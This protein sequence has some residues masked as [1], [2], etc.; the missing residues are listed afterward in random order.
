MRASWWMASS[1]PSPV[2]TAAAGLLILPS[3]GQSSSQL[4]AAATGVSVAGA[5]FL[6]IWKLTCQVQ[7]Y[8]LL[9][10]LST[11]LPV[12]LPLFSWKGLYR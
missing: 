6:L 11:S 7:F 4:Q 1:W 8:R 3:W 10:A 9:S 5:L 2:L 12:G